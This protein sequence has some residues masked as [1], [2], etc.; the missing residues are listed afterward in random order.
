MEEG[1]KE[2]F[3]KLCEGT[4][5]NIRVKFQGDKIFTKAP[6]L[7]ISNFTLD[8]CN[9]PHFK[10]VRLKTLYWQQADFLKHS[11]LKPYP[12]CLFDIYKMYDVF[13]Q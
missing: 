1:A 10:D 6:V 13:L 3:K 2:D 5:L 4:S 11:Q 9:D 12:L 7:L 8:I